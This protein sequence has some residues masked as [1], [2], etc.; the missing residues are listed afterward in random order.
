[1]CIRDRN[2]D[3][4]ASWFKSP[5]GIL[6]LALIGFAVFFLIVIGILAVTGALPAT[7]IALSSRKKCLL[8]SDYG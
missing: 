5:L 1:M 7:I 4:I 2:F 6:T 3:A 8:Q